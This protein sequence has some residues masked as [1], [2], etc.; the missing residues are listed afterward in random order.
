MY[1][2]PYYDYSIAAT[3]FSTIAI[4]LINSDYDTIPIGGQLAVFIAVPSSIAAA[5]VTII[6]VAVLI[7]IMKLLWGKKSKSKRSK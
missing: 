4:I 6:I 3:P 2:I 5:I 1:V 7:V